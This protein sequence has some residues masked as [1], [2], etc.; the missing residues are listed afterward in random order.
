VQDGPNATNSRETI[1]AA[2]AA[3]L[4]EHGGPTAV[5]I[6]AI[7]ARARVARGTLYRYFP[8]KAAIF[9]A[10]ADEAGIAVPAESPSTRERILEAASD[11]VLR[12]GFAATTMEQIAERA[13]VRPPTIYRHFASKVDLLIALAERAGL[14]E[15]IR[16]ALAHGAAGDPAT[17]LRA[18]GRLL[19]ID[20]AERFAVL[21]VCIAEGPA[22]PA[23]GGEVM[24]RLV[25]P[26]WRTLGDY[27]EAQVTAGRL[28]PGPTLPRVYSL[29]GVAIA[30]ALARR[31]FGEL[32]PFTAEELAETML[33]TFLHGAATPAYRTQLAARRPD[34]ISQMT[35]FGQ[36]P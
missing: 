27:I 19:L 25:L 28:E 22:H 24:R 11:L 10:L 30:F 1:L 15:E 33:T 26:V 23:V 18:L 2:A 9:A 7:A 14:L 17:D 31:M 12:A 16:V 8:S 13:G 36:P 3:L 20:E 32:L 6:D 35:G 21:A 4:E 34:D 29:A 5:R